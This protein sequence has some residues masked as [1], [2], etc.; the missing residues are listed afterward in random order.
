MTQ[1]FFNFSM[2]RLHLIWVT[3]LIEI[4]ISCD[5]LRKKTNAKTKF[6]WSSCNWLKK[7]FIVEDVNKLDKKIMRRLYG[8]SARHLHWS[9]WLIRCFAHYYF[10]LFKSWFFPNLETLKMFL[11]IN[12]NHFSI[13]IPNYFSRSENL[14]H[15][16]NYAKNSTVLLLRNSYW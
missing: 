8:Q 9:N 12:N 15:Y 14:Y 1:R 4:T 16:N 11:I 5:L 13:I 10:K 6:I 3:G 2:E 7:C